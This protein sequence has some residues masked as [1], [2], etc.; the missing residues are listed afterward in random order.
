MIVRKTSQDPLKFK[1]SGHEYERPEFSRMLS[2]ILQGEYSV[3]S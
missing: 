2:D 3:T 1:S